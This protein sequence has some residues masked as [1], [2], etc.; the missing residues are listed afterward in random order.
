MDIPKK[1]FEKK[2]ETIDDKFYYYIDITFEE[3]NMSQYVNLREFPFFDYV[4][5]KNFYTQILNI[6]IFH[7]EKWKS[8]LSDLILMKEPDSDEDAERYFIINRKQLSLDLKSPKPI[9]LIRFYL[10]QESTVWNT[11]HISDITFIKEVQLNNEFKEDCRIKRE[12]ERIEF[13]AT[14]NSKIN[15]LLNKDDSDQRF[16]ELMKGGSD[17]FKI[18][19]FS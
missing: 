16:V 7:N 12:K 5:F 13:T 3:D 14:D 15:L 4:I 2:S 10:S 1:I 6:F 19:F 11:F 18:K 17:K 9:Q 8:I